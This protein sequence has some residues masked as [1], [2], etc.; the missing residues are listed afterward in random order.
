M[1]LEFSAPQ[2]EKV[3]LIS[4]TPDAENT[5]AYCARVSNPAN[6]ENPE[7]SK[8]LAFCIKHGHWS[9]FEQANMVLDNFRNY[10]NT[11]RFCFIKKFNFIGKIFNPL[12]VRS[13]R[14]RPA[15]Y[16]AP[17]RYS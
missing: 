12:V 17:L 11:V 4:A 15:N 14:T 7:I 16:S 1:T 6:Q 2:T 3:R 5:I 8:L 9:I 13:I 10:Q